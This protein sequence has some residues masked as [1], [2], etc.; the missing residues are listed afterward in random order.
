MSGEAAAEEAEINSRLELLTKLE[1]DATAV[2][3]VTVDRRDSVVIIA[4][5]KEFDRE[6]HEM[7]DY[8]ESENERRHSEIAILEVY[9]LISLICCLCVNLFI[10]SPN[11]L[12]FNLVL[13]E[14]KY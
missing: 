4:E 2:A 10:I 6:V 11:F 12:S 13:L 7:H 14:C 1:F 8:V 5:E 3:T 9:S